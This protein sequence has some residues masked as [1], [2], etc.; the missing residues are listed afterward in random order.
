MNDGLPVIEGFEKSGCLSNDD[1]RKFI[2]EKIPVNHLGNCQCVIYDNI[3][4]TEDHSGRR[5]YGCHWQFGSSAAGFDGHIFIYSHKG[6]VTTGFTNV[7]TCRNAILHTIA[8]EIGHNERCLLKV[9]DPEN[10]QKWDELHLQSFELYNDT[11]FEG[12][13]S[14]YAKE[15]AE[16]DF[17]ESYADFVCNDGE[18]LMQLSVQ[19]YDLIS[20]LFRYAQ[21][22]GNSNLLNMPVVETTNW[23][24]D[25]V[26]IRKE[27]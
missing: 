17:A 22:P 10:Y 15:N 19:K 26:K 9:Q 18:V 21:T 12:F 14:Q 5:Q 20:G 11:S 23:R 8:H 1:V 6:L 25:V 16:E 2:D 27:G 7:R 3:V 13:V 24:E 4:A